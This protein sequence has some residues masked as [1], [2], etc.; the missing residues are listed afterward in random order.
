MDDN[1]QLLMDRLRGVSA[2]A[3]KLFC[4]VVRQAY[5]GPMR[6][7]PAGVATPVEILE[8]CGLDVGEFYA[9]LELLKER[10]LI[11]VSGNY[12]F[13]EIRLTAESSAAEALAERCTKMGVPVEEVFVGLETNSLLK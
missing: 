7:K 4:L 5:H 12:P 10:G 13:E 6:P 8:A 2:E 3:R 1:T 11:E 9:L